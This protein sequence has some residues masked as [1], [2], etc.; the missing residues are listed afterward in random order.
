M[1]NITYQESHKW[2]VEVNQPPYF[3][4]FI[5]G[6]GGVIGLS[7]DDD[8]NGL[9][10][11]MYSLHLDAVD[12][13]EIVRARI[14]SFELLLNGSMRLSGQRFDRMPIT[15]VRF[16]HIKTKEIH[17]MGATDI[18]DYPF[19]VDLPHAALLDNSSNNI[20]ASSKLLNLAKDHES[21]R[22]LLF[23]AGLIK[24]I[25]TTDRI[26]AWSILYKILETVKYFYKEHSINF[27]DKHDHKEVQAFTTACN[28]RSVLG[29][30]ARHGHGKPG[31]KPPTNVLTDLDDAIKF[32]FAIANEFCKEYI[33]THKL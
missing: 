18:A 17:S 31:K 23:M 12:D 22:T 20:N 29:M 7:Y 19:E 11:T 8:N 3:Q 10:N 14:A 1:N 33:R 15:F 5:Q 2:E 6:V 25:D 24:T 28:L 30:Y 13:P 27:D 21:I 16:M 4:S 9:I 26:L 32:I